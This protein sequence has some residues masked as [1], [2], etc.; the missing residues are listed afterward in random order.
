MVYIDVFVVGI[1]GVVF[2]VVLRVKLFGLMI[3]VIDKSVKIGGIFCYLGFGCWI[4]NIY[5][6]N[7][8]WDSVEKVL[9]YMENIIGDVGLVFFF[10]RK[11]IFLEIGFEMVRWLEKNGYWW[12]FIFGYLDYFFD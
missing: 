11:C 7:D 12:Y 3:L 2:I 4:L 8:K 1:G 10:E 5:L 6:Y 9:M